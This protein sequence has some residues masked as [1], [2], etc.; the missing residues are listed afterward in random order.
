M[1]PPVLSQVPPPPL[2]ACAAGDTPRQTLQHLCAPS[3]PPFRADLRPKLR[4]TPQL[5]LEN[6]ASKLPHRPPFWLRHCSQSTGSFP[7]RTR[8]G[9]QSTACPGHLEE[10][11]RLP[12]EPHRASDVGTQVWRGFLL[13]V[14]ETILA[15]WDG[16]SGGRLATSS[17]SL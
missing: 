7:H 9:V 13:P 17:K 4:S 2:P 3:R 10:T 1:G 8:L 12:A 15:N 16:R 5:S 14:Q 6:P 11:E